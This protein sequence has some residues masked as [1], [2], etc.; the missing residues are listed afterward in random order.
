VASEFESSTENS[1]LKQRVVDLALERGGISF[2]EFMETV[3]YEP[4]LGYYTGGRETIGREGD[5]LTSP[6]VS[7]IFGA[8]IGRQLRE[9]W[10]AMGRPERFDV[11]ECGAGN[12]T[13]AR[14]ILTWSHRAAAELHAAISYRIVE[15]NPALRA[16]QRLVLESAD[17]AGRTSWEEAVPQE[18]EGCM[19]SNEL[20]DAMPV[21][22]V[23][24]E[25]GVLREVYVAWE[26]G[27]FREEL[28]APSLEVI[29]YFD[30]LGLLPGEGCHAEV[31]LAALDWVRDAARALAAGFFLTFDYGY[32]AE[33]L[34][35]PWRKDGTLLGFY[36]HNPSTDPY[37]RIGRQDLTS[38]VDFTSVRRAGEAAGMTTLRLA[39]QS[40][41]LAGLG[42]TEALEHAPEGDL[43]EMFARRRAVMEL[44]DP[45]GLGRIK[46]LVQ[47][48]GGFALEP[49]VLR[50]AI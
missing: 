31:N 27:R 26:G 46:V 32:E 29:G 9:M 37:A 49:G 38:H 2:R 30:A 50:P 13:L 33:E 8:M 12:G 4:R 39:S 35:A 43:E 24:V 5:Y 28:R 18:T 16:R 45:G 19:L 10:V 40:E 22:R 34:Y 25:S 41:Y 7:P 6:E 21:H 44:L 36:R 3:L 11:V 42:I 15:P 48:K 17:L 1:A 20:L 23:A 14:D 47:A